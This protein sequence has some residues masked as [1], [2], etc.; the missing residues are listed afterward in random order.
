MNRKILFSS[1]IFTF[2]LFVLFI[3][4]VN[5]SI[6]VS[7]KD[8]KLHLPDFPSEV[9]EYNYKIVVERS[10]AEKYVLCCRKTPFIYQNKCGHFGRYNADCINVSDGLCVFYSIRP[11]V[12]ETWVEDT[13]F[14]GDFHGFSGFNINWY[15][16]IYSNADILNKDDGTV[17]FQK[18]PLTLADHLEKAEAV[19][20]FKD[21]M[22]KLVVSL[23]MFLIGLIGLRK[24]WTFLRTAL[25]RA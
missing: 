12:D 8:N 16:M 10:N 25:H 3:G 21:L 24:A 11:G 9:S 17:F 2:C 22:K 4:N 15:G 6:D 14:R 1:I 7:Y 13:Y 18:T 5:A 23:I 19:E 20:M